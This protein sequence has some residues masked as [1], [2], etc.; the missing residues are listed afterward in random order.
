VKLDDQLAALRAFG[1]DAGDHPD[2]RL[3]VR[4]SLDTEP[5]I[6]RQLVS[7]AAALAI[8]LGGTVSW[9]LVTGNLGKLW[10]S[11]REHA[12]TMV[13]QE[14]PHT[15]P[16]MV[17][18]PPKHERMIEPPPPPP[19]PAPPPPP[20]PEPAPAPEP[21]KPHP[22]PPPHKIAVA[23]APETA[24]AAPVEALYRKAHEL[25]FHGGDRAEALAAWD[26]YLA[27]EPT[28]RFAVEARYNRALLL[29]R[30]GRFADA[31]AALEP[32]ARGSVEPAG[33]RQREATMLIDRLDHR[34]KD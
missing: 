15:A 5:V 19:D 21:V 11:V 13:E 6:R 12:T 16:P 31:R 20:Q 27:A 24:P 1:D 34:A 8:L 26:A 10:D 7:V 33:Y 30:L 32:F 22:A 29:V 9:A 25:H 28:G 14:V 17:T 2:T 4:R 3:R 23:P 18:P